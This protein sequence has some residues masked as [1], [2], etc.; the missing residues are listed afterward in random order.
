MSYIN[1]PAPFGVAI[2]PSD[3]TTYNPPLRKLWVGVTGH[4]AVQLS[5]MSTALTLS[6]VPVGMLDDLRISKVMAT[7]TTATTMVGFW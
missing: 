3:D 7:G 1:E 5:G 4:I 2:T 6:N